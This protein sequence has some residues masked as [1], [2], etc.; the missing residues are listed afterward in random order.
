M[1]TCELEIRSECGEPYSLFAAHAVRT[2]DLDL[3]TSVW[4]IPRRYIGAIGTKFELQDEE[5]HPNHNVPALIA[6]FDFVNSI[7]K[8]PCLFVGENDLSHGEASGKHLLII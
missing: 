7:R 4:H 2:L 5:S 3:G 6:K 1:V 8:N